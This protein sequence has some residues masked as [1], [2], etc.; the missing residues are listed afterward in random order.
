[1]QAGTWRLW[2]ESTWADILEIYKITTAG[3]KVDVYWL[4]AVSYSAWT[5]KGNGR[6]RLKQDKGLH[7]VCKGPLQLLSKG[8]K[9]SNVQ[10][11]TNTN[12]C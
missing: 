5:L 9:F 2:K 1:M 4:F 6:E 7:A 12:I 11:E 10:E 3:K 8:Q